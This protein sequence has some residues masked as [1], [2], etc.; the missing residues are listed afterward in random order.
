MPFVGGA[1][2]IWL[3]HVQLKTVIWVRVAQFVS[4]CWPHVG[5]H[6]NREKIQGSA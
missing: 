4:P 2:G 1:G 5:W 6:R 3:V